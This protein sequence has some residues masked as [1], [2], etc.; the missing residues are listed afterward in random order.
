MEFLLT[1]PSRNNIHCAII[2]P[3]GN[4]MLTN[5]NTRT[6][7][8]ICSKLTIK[9]PER[10]HLHRSGVFI[11]NFEHIPYLVLV[12]LL[13]ILNM[14]WAFTKPQ[15]EC[16]TVKSNNRELILENYRMPFPFN[17]P[18]SVLTQFISLDFFYALS[19]NQRFPDFS[20]GIERD[21]WQKMD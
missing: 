10:R 9:S 8:E 19:E 1:F 21:Q 15:F 13:F 5:R 16:F 11:V 18:M 3:T 17:F 2:H 6:K 14:Y 20:G 12:F 7:F 4:Y